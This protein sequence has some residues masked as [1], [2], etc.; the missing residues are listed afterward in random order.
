VV[1]QMLPAAQWRPWANTHRQ[2]CSCI[3]HT[4][5]WLFMHDHSP[6]L[7]AAQAERRAKELQETGVKVKLV[8]VG[9]KGTV[10]FKRRAKLYNLSSGFGTAAPAAMC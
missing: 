3:W 7:C 6:P 10:Y 4:A 8:T 9:K 1:I 5:R 2:L